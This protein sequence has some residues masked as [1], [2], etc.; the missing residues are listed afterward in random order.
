LLLDLYLPTEGISVSW[1]LVS[2]IAMTY[3]GVLVGGGQSRRARR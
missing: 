1:Y 3:L 2:G